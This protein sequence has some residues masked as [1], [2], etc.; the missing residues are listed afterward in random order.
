MAAKV[1]ESLLHPCSDWTEEVP[2]GVLAGRLP[3]VKGRWLRGLGFPKYKTGN[4]YSTP[5]RV[6]LK[7][8]RRFR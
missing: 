6:N 2:E 5:D 3:Y 7:K 1:L 4:I 8:G